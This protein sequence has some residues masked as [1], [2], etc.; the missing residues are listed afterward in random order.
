MHIPR[1]SRSNYFQLNASPGGDVF[2]SD[3]VVLT[4]AGASIPVNI[5]GMG[6]MVKQ[7]KEGQRQ[8][9]LALKAYREIVLYGVPED[10]E[11]VLQFCNHILELRGRGFKTLLQ[12]SA[13]PM[14][15]RGA[16]KFQNRLNTKINAAGVLKDELTRWISDVCLKFDRGKAQQLF[17]EFI[18]ILADAEIP[19]FTTNYDGV[20]DEGSE[21]CNVQVSDNF[22]PDQR[23]RMFWDDTHRAF[24]GP[25]LR[26]VKMHGSIY[27]HATSDNTRVEKLR[28]PAQRNA[29]GEELSQLL[30]FP[31]RFKD[32]YQK[33][34]FPLY[35]GF[36][37]TLATATTMLVI[38]HSLR[39]EY[40]LAAVRER[41]KEKSFG[42]V[43]VDISLPATLKGMG[44]NVQLLKGSVEEFMPLLC[45]GISDHHQN[46]GLYGYI[47]DAHSKLR[48]GRRPK[49]FVDGVPQW[50]E[51]G[52]VLSGIALTFETL[53]S[54]YS[55]NVTLVVGGKSLPLGGSRADEKLRGYGRDKRVVS[56]QIP[57]NLE[58]GRSY[59][60][61]FILHDERRKGGGA[62][63]T[64]T[65]RVRKQ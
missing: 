26:I 23:G 32:I 3:I 21:L 25:G 57:S 45:R 53:S 19:V 30:I 42:L 17:G 13:G 56:L 16:T 58:R 36:T 37:R 18:P 65:I 39:D 54:I 62:Q 44:G 11:E 7:F 2:Q 52:Q 63:T 27:W 5:P 49:V 38:G 47:A 48:S 20:L 14:G 28:Q 15:G 50:V 12:E 1:S 10:L 51:A 29:E 41:L 43:V 22:A 60:L 6:G 4:G 9:S 59:K 33:N 8:S 40:L 31:T 34:Y 46:G 64:K 61:R 35:S 55:W 24:S